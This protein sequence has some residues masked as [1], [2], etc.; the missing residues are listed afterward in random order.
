MFFVLSTRVKIS[1][2]SYLRQMHFCH[3]ISE[4]LYN[5]VVILFPPHW[6]CICMQL[7]NQYYSSVHL[8]ALSGC[9]SMRKSL[10][11]CSKDKLTFWIV[12]RVS[13]VEGVTFA[14]AELEAQWTNSVSLNGYSRVEYTTSFWVFVLNS[15][16][17]QMHIIMCP[18]QDR[19][20][21]VIK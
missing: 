12:L 2:A 20:A 18:L 3:W 19:L 15:I 5:S 1:A 9:I 10:P 17:V 11:L 8:T 14:G 4:F 7:F 16:T 13:L 21:S 6:Q